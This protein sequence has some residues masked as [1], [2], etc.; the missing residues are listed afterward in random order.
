MTMSLDVEVMHS[1]HNNILYELF[2]TCMLSTLITNYTT[3]TNIEGS[4]L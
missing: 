2:S 4:A 1:A 3:L